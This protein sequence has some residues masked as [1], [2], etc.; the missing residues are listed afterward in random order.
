[1][2]GPKPFVG[3]SQMSKDKPPPL[4]YTRF[5]FTD[6][7]SDPAVVCMTNEQVGAYLRLLS[8]CWAATP[9]GHLPDDDVYLASVSGMGSLWP[10]HRFAMAKA[11][12]VKRGKWIQRRV[13]REYE[14]C[15]GLSEVRSHAGKLGAEALWQTHGKRMAKDGRDRGRDRVRERDREK[16][17]PNT[18]CAESSLRESSTPAVFELPLNDNTNF[19][20]GQPQLD[21]WEALYPAVDVPQ[22][23]REIIGWCEANPR[24]R[25]TRSGVLRFCAAWLSREQDKGN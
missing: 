8:A 3:A 15:R 4:P 14:Y 6:F 23:M 11:F 2:T 12:E 25:K 7:F 1:M 16:T 13:V 17:T 19:P 24:K 22:T 20:I 18:S 21:R 9:P 5:S 10:A